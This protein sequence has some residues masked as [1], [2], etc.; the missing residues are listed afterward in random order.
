MATRNTANA[1]H[2]N[3]YERFA[4][5]L[6]SSRLSASRPQKLLLV[7]SFANPH[8]SDMTSASS[9]AQHDEVKCP[10]TSDTELKYAFSLHNGYLCQLSETYNHT[11]RAQSGII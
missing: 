9:Q 10:T 5:P 3:T 6:V 7:N 2:S 8:L 1:L 4:L 11:A